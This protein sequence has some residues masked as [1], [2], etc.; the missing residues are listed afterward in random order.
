MRQMRQNTKIIMILVAIT[1]VAL[2][3]FEWGMNMSGRTAGGT[4]GRVGGTTVSALDFQNSYRALYDQVQAAQ[5]QPISSQQDQEIEDMAWEQVVNQ[6]LI[7]EELARRGIRV[8]DEEVRQAARMSPPP[9]FQ[10]DPA[11]QNEQ[12]QFDLV[13][14]QQFLSEAGQDPL[15]LQQLELYYRDLILRN[16]LMRQVT[17]GVFLTDAE[18]WK[19]Y[20]DENEQATATFIA[21]SPDTRVADSEI[22]VT[23]DEVREYYEE[24]EETFQVPARATVRYV[25]MNK[26]PS[27][28]DTAAALER[29][30]AVYQEVVGGADFATVAARESSDTGSAANGGSLGTFARGTM[31]A[32]FD[33]V[34]FALDLNEI[35]EP[36][37]TAYGYHI[38]QVVG[39]DE[40]TDRI[41]ARHILIPIE[42][43]D[44]SEVRLLTRAD[45]LET[46][47]EG[48]TLESAATTFGLTILDG[49]ITEETAVLSGVGLAGEAQDWIFEE[50]EGEG[51]VSPVFE[52]DAAFYA[53]EIVS[54]APAGVLSF[55]EARAD[56]ENDLRI[57]RKTERTMEEAAG[58]AAELRGGSVTLEAL[59]DRIGVAPQTQGPFTRADF[60]P[61]LGLSSPAIGAAFGVPAG[62]IAGP[63]RAFDAV[64]VMR[65]DSRVPAD[66][67]A[68]EAQKAQQ[69]TAL[70]SEVQQ[71]RLDQWL[72]GLR[73]T[74]RIVDN[75]IEYFRLAEE[76]AEQG[77]QNPLL[78]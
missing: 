66:S 50:A 32:E 37:R 70:T 35:S 55:E 30:R 3:V 72:D 29:A 43:T 10:A 58:W 13:R 21:V 46:L 54:L 5:E 25:Y 38:V 63:A 24:N 15:F 23:E 64:V 22:P 71:V 52:T 41:E 16:K 62:G 17:S 77:L 78:Y 47:A 65:V 7:Q 51:S 11:F 14:Y 36:F 75:R 40:A 53:V 12:G 42:V 59:A 28:A 4:I 44:E 33:T 48:Q 73:E 19:R 31:V 39:Q 34:A 57:E 68:W 45:S 49:E 56:I 69:R 1:F 60:V 74:T 8:T 26:A 2:M 67:A 76:Q 27:A 18:L 6:I 20:R 9:E 61:G